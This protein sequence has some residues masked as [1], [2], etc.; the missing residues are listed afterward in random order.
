MRF[1]MGSRVASSVASAWLLYAP[2]TRNEL[3][4]DPLATYVALPFMQQSNLSKMQSF[5]YRSHSWRRVGE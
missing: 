4:Y 1:R 2:H 3:L 5:S